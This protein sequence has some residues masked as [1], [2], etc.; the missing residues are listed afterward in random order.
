MWVVDDISYFD[1]SIFK[2][3][4]FKLLSI[5]CERAGKEQNKSEVTILKS[6]F[7]FH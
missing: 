7:L 4:Y 5:Y 2:V 3:L 1:N 6:L